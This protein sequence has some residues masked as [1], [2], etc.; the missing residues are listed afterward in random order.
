VTVSPQVP[1]R[2]YENLVDAD[3]LAKL[4]K[5]VLGAAD[6]VLDMIKEDIDRQA[7]WD[8]AQDLR[9]QKAFSCASGLPHRWFY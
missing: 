9:E 5:V 6:R 4:Q 2:P 1:Q 3:Q 8:E 7:K